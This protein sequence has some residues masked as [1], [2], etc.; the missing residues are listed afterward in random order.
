MYVF[1]EFL[2]KPQNPKTPKPHI[3]EIIFFFEIQIQMNKI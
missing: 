2:P 3:K 1:Y